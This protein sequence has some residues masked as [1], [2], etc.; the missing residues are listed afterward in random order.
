MKKV[1][2]KKRQGP[3]L[4]ENRAT[5]EVVRSDRGEEEAVLPKEKNR[6]KR[7]VETEESSEG[8]ISRV[9]GKVRWF[10]LVREFLREVR[11]ELKKVTW[12]TRKETLAATV[13]VIGLSMLVA[14]IL[15]LL[16]VGLTRLVA[17]ILGRS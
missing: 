7:V 1:K 4:A 12:P 9:S 2:A 16:D 14:F 13:M 15:G 17:V 8:L 5:A 11:I 3:A 10:G 6:V